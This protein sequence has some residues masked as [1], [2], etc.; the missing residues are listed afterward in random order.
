MCQWWSSVLGGIHSGKQGC[1]GRSSLWWMPVQ[2]VGNCLGQRLGHLYKWG[3]SCLCTKLGVQCGCVIEHVLERL[4]S[5]QM[6]HLHGLPWCQ[7]PTV[8][9][10]CMCSCHVKLLRQNVHDIHW[11]WTLVGSVVVP[12]RWPWRSQIGKLGI[13][14]PLDTSF[15][16]WVL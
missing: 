14:S 15:S 12:D 4:G 3:W 2:W 16:S 6:A 1:Y 13:S 10:L 8:A 7:L 11:R 9:V 5:S